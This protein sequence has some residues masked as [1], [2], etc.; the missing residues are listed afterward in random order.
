M[1]KTQSHVSV[2]LRKSIGLETNVLHAIIQDI[3][4]VKSENVSYVQTIKFMMSALK[5]V[6]IAQIKFHF[7]MERNAFLVK[8][9]N[10]TTR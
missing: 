6:L 9:D 4:T 10:S 7:S 5:N 8:K 3:L 1:I 2:P